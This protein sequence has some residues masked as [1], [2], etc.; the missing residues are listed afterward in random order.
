MAST[1]TSPV[2]GPPLPGQG[3][4]GTVERTDDKGQLGKQSFM[5]LLIAQMQHQDPL[6]PTD[7]SQMM[8]QM[9]QFASVEGLQ[10]LQAQMTSMNLSQDFSYATSLIGRTVTWKDPKG[11][12]HSGVV[13]RVT[14]D[15][16][17]AVLHVADEQFYSG[18]ISEVR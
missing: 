1:T 16:K 14:P 7:S 9:A 6:Q 17:G 5:K 3:S 10:N 12:E 11:A 8:A 13:D 15:P 4:P 2:S 18:Q